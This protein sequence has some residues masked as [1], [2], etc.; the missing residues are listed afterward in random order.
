MALPGDDP[1]VDSTGIYRVAEMGN[2]ALRRDG[3]Q[4]GVLVQDVEYKGFS[5]GTACT[6]C[7]VWMIT[8]VSGPGG[9]VSLS[10][11]SVYLLVPVS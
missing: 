9:Q 3:R 2:V 4:L 7:R 10:W 1:K 11:D 5:M 8:F 6:G